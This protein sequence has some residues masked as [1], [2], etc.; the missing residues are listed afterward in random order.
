MSR[1]NMEGRDQMPAHEHAQHQED[2]AWDRRGANS[3]P[4]S[5][6]T[7][8]GYHGSGFSSHA[9]GVE[10]PFRRPDSRETWGNGMVE[11]QGRLIA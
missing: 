9:P 5:G 6:Y 1:M 11:M 4:S 8:Q 10:T 3:H 7:N 2:K